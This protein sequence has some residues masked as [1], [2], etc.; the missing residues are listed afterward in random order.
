MLKSIS[1]SGDFQ[2][3]WDALKASYEASDDTISIIK[4]AHADSS[5][6]Q[7]QSI[8]DKFLVFLDANSISHDSVGIA[9]VMNFLSYHAIQ[10]KRE[11]RTIAAYKCAVELPLKLV[12]GIDFESTELGLFMRGLFNTKPPRNLLP[13]PL[14]I[15]T[16]YL[17]I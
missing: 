16:F 5:L 10:F 11:Y 12:L 2:F 7:Y 9:D 13:C 8:W 3:H 14:G 4:K 6:R 15:L 1:K 17:N